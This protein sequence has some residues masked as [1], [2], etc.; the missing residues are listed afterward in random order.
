MLQKADK[1]HSKGGSGQFGEEPRSN[2]RQSA[3]RDIAHV[4]AGERRA[5]SSPVTAMCG[6]RSAQRHAQMAL[7]C[8]GGVARCC[9]HC[10]VRGAIRAETNARVASLQALPERSEIRYGRGGAQRRRANGAHR[11]DPRQRLTA[12][13]GELRKPAAKI[14]PQT[15][16]AAMY[17]R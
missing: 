1:Q 2:V 12:K 7:C 4:V 11:S 8:P 5:L 13:G 10:C 9:Q 6:R 17:E 14:M 16:D 15:R 3:E